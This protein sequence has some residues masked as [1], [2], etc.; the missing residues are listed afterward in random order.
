MTSRKQELAELAQMAFEAYAA[1]VTEVPEG[2][3]PLTWDALE[4]PEKANWVAV[5]TSLHSRLTKPVEL[6]NREQIIVSESIQY[7]KG[8]RTAFEEL[9]DKQINRVTV[10]AHL[11]K[12]LGI[13]R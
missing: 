6:L 8:L 11:A 1:S 3:E 5:A 12:A 4:A 9:G 7:M 10:I 13:H 2:G